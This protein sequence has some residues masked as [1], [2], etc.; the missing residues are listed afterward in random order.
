MT[1]PNTVA[2]KA[3]TS[4][5]ATGWARISMIILAP[6]VLGAGGWIASATIAGSDRLTSL[7]SRADYHVTIIQ[8]NRGDIRRLEDRVN[9]MSS[10]LAAVAPQITAINSNI[11]EIKESLNRMAAERREGR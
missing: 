11:A 9:E 6:A 2:E 3:A 7:E 10:V 4:V 1:W 5:I 8:E